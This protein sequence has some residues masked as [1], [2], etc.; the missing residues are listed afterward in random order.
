MP[1]RLS[2][3]A[4]L[5]LGLI[6]SGCAPAVICSIE[7]VV[8]SDYSCRRVLRL[9]ASP[10]PAVP[11]QRPRLGDYFQF[12]PAELYETYLAQPEK[13]A[14]AGMF[15]SYENI[16]PDLARITPGTNLVAK[17]A[18]SFRVMDLVL[19]VLAD[20]DETIPDIVISREDGQAALA[21][22]IRLLVPEVMSVLNAR[23][24]AKYEL[25][26]LEQWLRNDVV[27][28]AVRIYGKAWEIH[29]A[30]RSGV[31][32]PGEIVELYMFLKDEA[33]REGLELAEL[34]TPNL[35]QENLRRLKEY[36]IRKAREL[37]PPRQSGGAPLSP[38]MLSGNVGE[39]LLGALQKAVTARHGSLNEFIKKVG[40]L[41]PRAFGAYLTG[42]A[43][44]LYML[45]ETTYF[46]RLR[47]PGMI[48]QTNG[49]RDVNGDI[50]WNFTDSDLALTGQ[51]MWARTMFVREPVLNALD[52]KGFP[53]SLA[54]VDRLFGMCVSPAGTPREALLMSL[55]QSAGARSLAPLEALSNT[56][57]SPD[58]QAAREVL[59]LLNKYRRQDGAAT[60]PGQTAPQNPPP[61][62][63]PAASKP[64]ATASSD[65][66]KSA[67]RSEPTAATPAPAAAA[68]P[69]R[70][71]NVTPT[72]PNATTGQANPLAPIKPLEDSPP[73]KPQPPPAS[74]VSP[75]EAW[76]IAPPPLPPAP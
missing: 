2:L 12:P 67:R 72:R 68:Q 26:R 45:P 16:H 10:N 8:M 49:V 64:A 36:A 28:K 30:K 56:A 53:S 48:M 21:E 74:G 61:V 22:L 57:S 65:Q 17:N 69:A 18:F 25:S 70:T 33:K 51:S 20:F 6:L 4:A 24:G 73:G 5:F 29:S 19:V 15:N 3:Y 47:V 1:R 63:A 27:A 23:Y 55:Q 34:G 60:G 31:T 71:Q 75:G 43:M 35:E 46:C 41:L 44:P 11:N 40:A 50:L 58:A 9:D 52:I 66:S 37:C 59:E 14:F 54:E 62:P 42:E 13:A 38:D 76:P 32:S 39:E 7:T